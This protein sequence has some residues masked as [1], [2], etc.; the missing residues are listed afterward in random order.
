[1]SLAFLLALEAL[2]PRMRAV[3]LLRDVFDFSVRET[4]DA[5]DLSQANVKVVHHRARRAMA[6]YDRDRVRPSRALQETTRRALEQFLHALGRGDAAGAAAQLAADARVVGDGGGRYHAARTPVVGAAKV[7]AFYT[8]LARRPD[9][10]VRFELRLLN[11]L[12][13][14]VAQ[15]ATDSP[16]APA[17][18]VIMAEA[19]AGGKLR[20]IYS[21][22]APDKLSA[23][24]FW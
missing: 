24:R 17:R 3:L 9:P 18:V 12:P 1:V 22:Q 5:L 6:A 16:G 4:A 23:V 10:V 19:D 2:T 13:A 14:F 7:A 21:V 20:R 8:K 15:Y 11:G